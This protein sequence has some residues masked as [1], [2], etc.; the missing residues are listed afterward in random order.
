M[1]MRPKWAPWFET[2][3]QDY[4]MFDPYHESLHNL[5]GILL[6][7]NFIAHRCNSASHSHRAGSYLSSWKIL[8]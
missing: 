5:A 2:G 6:L 8:N 3:P 1:V 7:M 4:P